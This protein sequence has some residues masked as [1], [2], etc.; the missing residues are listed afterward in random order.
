MK[1]KYGEDDAKDEDIL[2][3]RN[4]AFRW[5]FFWGVVISTVIVIISR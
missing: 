5:G 1:Q 3:F 2:A 4:Y